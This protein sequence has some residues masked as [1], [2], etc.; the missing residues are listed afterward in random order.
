MIKSNMNLSSNRLA[1]PTIHCFAAVL[2]LLCAL[3]TGCNKGENPAPTTTADTQN[4]KAT[5]VQKPTEAV[6]SA[7]IF[8]TPP[9]EASG[10][11]AMPNSDVKSD[12]DAAK[13]GDIEK[14]NALLQGKLKADS[15][16]ITDGG[17]GET[18]YGAFSMA[19]NSNGGFGSP[20]INGPIKVYIFRSVPVDDVKAKKL[21]IK[22]GS[23]YYW[24]NPKEFRYLRDVDLTMTDKQLCREFGLE[25][26]NSWHFTYSALV[27]EQ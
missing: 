19:M 25:T 27:H 7:A 24:P 18:A 13:S 2:I 3:L 10:A 5:S 15:I 21:G 8:P 20:T 4:I 14:V 22:A 16:V 12:N 1:H 17:M 11:P 26:D 6:K 23:A 9:S